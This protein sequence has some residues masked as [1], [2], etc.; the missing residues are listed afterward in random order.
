[1]CCT[2]PIVSSDSCQKIV[3]Q[4]RVVYDRVPMD[5]DSEFPSEIIEFQK[6]ESGLIQR[7]IIEFILCHSS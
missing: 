4:S 3:I 5:P 2:D 7:D 1:M 6:V